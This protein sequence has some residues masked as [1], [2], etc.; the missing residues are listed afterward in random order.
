MRVTGLTGGIACGK[1]AV[2]TLLLQA[3]IP[4]IDCDKMAHRLMRKVGVATECLTA[5]G[6]LLRPLW[7][8][9]L[10]EL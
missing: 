4:V 2:S 9:G 6:C 3:G 7:H 5:P 10:L 1:S 8:P